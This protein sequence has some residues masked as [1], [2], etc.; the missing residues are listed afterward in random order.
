MQFQNLRS[1]RHEMFPEVWHWGI[2]IH[3]RP[4]STRRRGDHRDRPNVARNRRYLVRPHGRFEEGVAERRA[5]CHHSSGGEV[6]GASREAVAA[7]V[8][9]EH[10][11]L[12]PHPRSE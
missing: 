12:R 2:G 11:G 6:V 7:V 1:F 5:R 9:R 10:M 4:S 3:V 8:N